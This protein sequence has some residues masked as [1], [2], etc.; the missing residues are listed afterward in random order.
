MVG[1]AGHQPLRPL[2]LRQ[3]APHFVPRWRHGQPLGALRP[4][5]ALQP[6]KLHIQNLAVKKPERADS[7]ILRRRGDR[8]FNGS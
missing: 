4:D 1:S 3:Q 2:Q 7:L 5:Q 6:I 8:S